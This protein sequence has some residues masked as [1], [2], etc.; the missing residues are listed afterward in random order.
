MI[1]ADAAEQS[2]VHTRIL[3]V[4]LAVDDC[5]AYWRAADVGGTLGER[6]ERAYAEHW[7]GTKSEARVRTL[8]KDMELRFDVYPEA[9]QA[10]R[11][12]QP[13]RE[14]APWVCH[15]HTQL[16]DP[17]YRAFTGDY[18]PERAAQG[19]ATVDRE[20]VGAWVQDTWPD[21]WAAATAKKFGG[22]LL[23]SAHAAGLVAG[24][25]DP[26][27]LKPVRAPAAAIEYAVFVLRRVKTAADLLDSP[28]LR[29]L[30]ATTARLPDVFREL[31]HVSLHS[32]GNVNDVRWKLPD[33]A[34]WVSAQEA[35]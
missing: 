33:L 27:E 28:Y 21:R 25:K 22:N 6:V 13:A 29:S 23:S 11:R 8:L 24:R 35:A 12:W 31:R 1:A 14:L 15:L 3:R 7:F 20:T 18:L 34:A 30:G 17:V 19:Y 16:A 9:L 10:L 4:M 26:R 32:L 2:E 5:V